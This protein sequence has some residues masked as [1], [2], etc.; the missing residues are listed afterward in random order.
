MIAESETRTKKVL[1]LTSR[2][3]NAALSWL[4][5]NGRDFL[6]II[7]NWLLLCLNWC[8]SVLYIT[9]IIPC[10]L[11]VLACWRTQ[12]RWSHTANDG[13]LK[14]HSEINLCRFRHTSILYNNTSI[15]GTCSKLS[16]ILEI[17]GHYCSSNTK[18]EFRIV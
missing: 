3:T 17:K 4:Y 5:E 16:S 15:R 14:G 12:I 18:A 10:S 2:P 7:G 13:G 9:R 8:E 6:K 11:I 1:I